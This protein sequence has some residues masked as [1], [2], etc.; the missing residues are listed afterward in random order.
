MDRL[1]RFAQRLTVQ[2]NS[3]QTAFVPFQTRKANNEARASSK[4]LE[5][6]ESQR[7]M[8]LWNAVYSDIGLRNGN[9]LRLAETYSLHERWQPD[10]FDDPAGL[11][12]YRIF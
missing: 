1:Q 5:S 2:G 3:Q 10:H 7:R 11:R 9:P 12:D 6:W 8:G 4:L